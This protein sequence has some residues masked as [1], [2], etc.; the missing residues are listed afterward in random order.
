MKSSMIYHSARS[1]FRDINSGCSEMLLYVDDLAL[2][3]GLIRRFKG[4]LEAWTGVLV[5]NG[6]RVNVKKTKMI[7]RSKKTR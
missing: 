5:S 2:A 1:M 4:Q 6:L 3:S 7:M